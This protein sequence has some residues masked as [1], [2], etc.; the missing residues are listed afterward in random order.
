MEFYECYAPTYVAARRKFCAAARQAGGTLYSYP[1]P[2]FK[3]TDGEL[4]SADVAVFGRSDA[5]RRL[6]IMSATHGLEGYAGSAAQVAWMKSGDVATL[7]HDVAVVMVHAVNPW[8]FSELSRTTENNVDLN[9]NFIDFS[10]PLPDNPA[11]A[12]LHPRL[13]GNEW[14]TASQ[15]AAQKAMDDFAAEHGQ[16][17][18]FDCL[19]CGQYSHPEGLNYGGTQREWSNELLERIVKEHLQGAQKTALIDW[20]TGI[21][22]YGEPFFLCFNPE[23]GKEHAQAVRWWGEKRIQGQQPHG[24]KRPQYKGLLFYGVQQ[25]L[26][27]TPM[28]G[29]VIEFGTRGWHMRR[30]LRLDLWLKFKADRDSDRYAMHKADLLDAFCPVDEIWR[31]STIRHSLEITRQAVRGLADWE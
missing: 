28:C 29:A 20:H 19:A 1:H 30:L 22:E 12:D 27:D 10:A 8:G 18:L 17:A 3:G 26:G 21:G 9:R 25:F 31:N 6:L 4:L 5:P 23:G 11:Y 16:D 2:H 14:T 15:A 24:R 7:A 13:L